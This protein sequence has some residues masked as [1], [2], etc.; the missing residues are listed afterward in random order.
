MLLLAVVL[1]AAVLFNTATLGILERRRELATRRALGQSQ[2][3]IAWSL[4]LEHGLLALLGL[5]VGLP[6]G[7]LAGRAVIS[8]YSSDLLSLPF[9]VSLRTVA[10][11][12]AGVLLVLLAAQAPALRA[13]ARTPI[14]EAVRGDDD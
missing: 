12:A 2:R 11:A 14:A 6:L 9:A 7:L 8:F 5:A 10:V 1:A 13:A 3:G 4:T